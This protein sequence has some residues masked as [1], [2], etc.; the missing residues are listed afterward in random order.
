V[1]SFTIDTVAPPAPSLTAPI[2]NAFLSTLRTPTF[3]WTLAAGAVRYRLE[4]NYNLDFSDVDMSFEGI[5]ATTFTLPNANALSDGKY[6]WRVVAI[7]A[8]GNEAISAFRIFTI[9]LP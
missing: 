6:A 7:D 4:F 9:D 3:T 8:A 2:S 1:R 5:T